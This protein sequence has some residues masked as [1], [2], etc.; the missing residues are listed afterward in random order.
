MTGPAVRL[1]GPMTFAAW[2]RVVRSLPVV[3]PKVQ[4]PAW[5]DPATEPAPTQGEPCLQCRAGPCPLLPGP[6][7]CCGGP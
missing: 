1:R 4:P 2:K 5:D 3:L 7:P 6:C